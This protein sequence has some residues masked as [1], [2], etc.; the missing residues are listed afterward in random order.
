MPTSWWWG[1]PG[2][3]V[4]TSCISSSPEGRDPIYIVDNL[5]SSEIE[6]VPVNDRVQ[7]VLGSIAEDRIL[8]AASARSRLRLSFGMLSR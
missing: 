7:F 1:A 3:S 5:L 4:R 8:A 2:L 6:N